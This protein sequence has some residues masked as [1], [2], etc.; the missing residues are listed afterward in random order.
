MR[1]RQRVTSVERIAVNIYRDEAVAEERDF[2]PE[3][4][5][6][7]DEEK[8]RYEK[9]LPRSVLHERGGPCDELVPA[10]PKAEDNDGRRDAEIQYDRER[11]EKAEKVNS[12]GEHG[13][14]SGPEDVESNQGKSSYK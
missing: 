11:R 3:K 7:N 12:P 2:D 14:V 4:Y 13:W 6:A 10:G 8:N 9:K 1:G 5:R